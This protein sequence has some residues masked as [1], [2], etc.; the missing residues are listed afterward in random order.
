MFR[1]MRTPIFLT[2]GAASV[3]LVSCGAFSNFGKPLSGDFDPLSSPGGSA[4]VQPG[5]AVVAPT[6]KSGQWVE[7]AMANAAFF[8]AIP[9]GNA[10]ADKVL[11]AA[12][13]MKVVSTKDTYV[14]VEL[15]SGEVG[16]V[17][18][19]MVIA[20]GSSAP[21]PVVPDYTPIPPPVDPATGTPTPAPTPGGVPP[22]VPVV[23]P[24]GPPAP[25]PGFPGTVPSVPDVPEPPTVPNVTE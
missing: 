15:D 18:E 8:K 11:P 10:R 17:P 20:R 9:R 6:Y 23:P 22:V 19:I 1:A 24:P 12:T 5:A 4:A 3:L 21:G 25:A 2:Y 16:Y 14:K 7:T 13:P